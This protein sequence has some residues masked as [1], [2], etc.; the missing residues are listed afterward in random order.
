MKKFHVSLCVVALVLA[1]F[2]SA[3][4]HRAHAE[5]DRETTVALLISGP[6][7][8]AGGNWTRI[9]IFKDDETFTTQGVPKEHG[10]WRIDNNVIVLTFADKHKDTM[11]LPLTPT[12]TPGISDTNEPL[13]YTLLNAPPA[14]GTPASAGASFPVAAAPQGT[15]T[16]FLQKLTGTK[17]TWKDKG[18]FS[19]DDGGVAAGLGPNFHWKLV[20]PYV[21]EYSFTTFG[22]YHGTI[23]FA[24][25]MLSAA[26]DEITPSGSHAP[27]TLRRAQ[28]E[29]A[30][31]PPAGSA[32]NPPP[33]GAVLQAKD[34]ATALLV[35]AP[36]KIT[37]KSWFTIRIFAK[38]GTFTTLGWPDESGTWV[39]ENNAV[40]LTFN[41]DGHKE[42]LT[43]PLD[44]KGTGGFDKE[45]KPLAAVQQNPAPAAPP[46]VMD[47]QAAAAAT[48]LLVSAP[49]K[50]KGGWWSTVRVF[51]R[52]GTFTTVGNGG[53]HGTWKFSNN[54][55]VLT[56]PDGHHDTFMLPLDPKGTDGADRDG[57]P[58]SAAVEV[59]VAQ[60]GNRPPA[61]A[62]NT[63]A[64]GGG[65]YFGSG[66][67]L[68][69]PAQVQTPTPPPIAPELQQ[70]AGELVK[71]YH[72][73]LVFVSGKDAAG[74][75]FI[76][77][78]GNANFLITNAHVAAGIAD[79]Q[80]RTL[81]DTPVQGGA[82][83]VA[84]GR[85]IFCMALPAGGKPLEIMQDVEG[86]AAIGDDVVV[87]GNAGGEGVINTITGKITG[88]GPNLV[89][90]DAPFVHGN[91]GSPI[92]HLKTGKV[93]GVATYVTTI[94]YDMTT[95]EK[96]SQPVIRR[97]GYRLDNVKSWQAVNWQAFNAQAAEMVK[98]ET[99]TTDLEDFFADVQEN[100]GTVTPS[101]HTNP[102]IKT[103]IDQWQE[104][105][106][107]NMSAEDQNRANAS[108][109]S[110]LKVACQQ[111]VTAARQRMTYDFF[112]RDLA[113][114]QKARDWM[115]RA[116]EEGIKNLRK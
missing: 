50:I 44:P 80:F 74:S 51:A 62:S 18:T 17:W 75:G 14:S 1:A 48:A 64:G 30:S 32:P 102:V 35:S 49:W 41:K 69:G 15:V 71:A 84:V 61:S 7:K 83:S 98:I 109:L 58:T 88:I 79:A 85:D 113:Q 114:Q 108:F 90:V 37:A 96:L 5:V 29:V 60:N 9:R 97:F 33:S 25:N 86:N 68:S 31:T 110:F 45:G 26:V 8:V 24:A 39:I 105:K 89:E 63:P 4:V 3:F 6:W 72:N 77:T 54:M 27:F 55:V 38:E 16:E 28:Q 116:F 13:V 70:R 20:K 115:S 82:A 52:D 91:S 81:D 43:L 95:L 19:F 42:T 106:S 23:T 99:L 46:K 59:A 112:A 40:T 36:W 94:N 87:L 103:I 11:T 2:Q 34:A 12:G 100:K 65:N 47:A 101:R 111:D 104:G 78:M 93:V 22:P 92:I 107:R 73:S 66:S 21:M 53:E 56:F 76:A 67:P 57:A 10:H